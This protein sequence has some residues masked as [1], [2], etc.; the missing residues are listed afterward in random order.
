MPLVRASAALAATQVVLD[1]QQAEADER[2]RR[3]VAERR[4]EQQRQLN[5]RLEQIANAI[6]HA[7]GRGERRAAIAV[8]P[9]S[10]QQ[11]DQEA[12]LHALREMDY[13]ASVGNEPWSFVDDD[14]DL[15]HRST[16]SYIVEW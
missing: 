12:V 3:T 14:G 6:R 8:S 5:L 15:R 16:L 7:T 1:R 13:K 9:S 10:W 11:E 4:L 2:S